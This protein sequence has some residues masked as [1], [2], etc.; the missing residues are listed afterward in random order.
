MPDLSRLIEIALSLAVG[1]KVQ[2][3]AHDNGRAAELFQA[4]TDWAGRSG[5]TH[6]Y[7]V[8]FQPGQSVS[9][10]THPEDVV[11]FYPEGA[12]TPVIV[13][14]E[15]IYPEAGQMY[16]IPRNA[17]HEVPY[18]TAKTSRISIAVKLTDE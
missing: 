3:V 18:N 1:Q 5:W 17:R 13:E 12:E 7:S 9:E 6:A 8:V 14:G 4:M 16:L 15:E 2:A 10:H 11:M